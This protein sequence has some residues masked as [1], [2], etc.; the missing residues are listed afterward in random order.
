MKTWR[1]KNFTAQGQQVLGIEKD[2]RDGSIRPCQ[3]V[4]AD[5]LCL[6]CSYEWDPALLPKSV[7]SSNE[8]TEGLQSQSV[9]CPECRSTGYLESDSALCG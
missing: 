2:P 4:P 6:N 1:S 8:F 7:V 9:T 5:I 3:P